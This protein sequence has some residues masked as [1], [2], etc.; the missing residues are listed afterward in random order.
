M[1]VDAIVQ[2]RPKLESA[3]RNRVERAQGKSDKSGVGAID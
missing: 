2:E 3:E 1:S